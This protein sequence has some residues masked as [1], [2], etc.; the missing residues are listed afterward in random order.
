[1]TER[2]TPAARA[3]L[4]GLGLWI[5]A[6]VLALLAA[7]RGPFGGF[8]MMDLAARVVA[9]AAAVYSLRAILRAAPDRKVVDD[10]G[11]GPAATYASASAPKENNF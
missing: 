9:L 11:A 3:L 4:P 8:S 2:A 10:V 5:I 7:A 6:G 1:M